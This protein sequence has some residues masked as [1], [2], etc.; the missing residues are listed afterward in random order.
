MT[1][2]VQ[3][4]CCVRPMRYLGE[5]PDVQGGCIHKWKCDKCGEAKKVDAP[6]HWSAAAAAINY[7]Q[8]P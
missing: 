5:W 1:V 6:P 4:Y 7:V 8:H 3:Q 2:V